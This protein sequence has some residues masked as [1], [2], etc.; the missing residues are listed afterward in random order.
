VA[1]LDQTQELNR[2]FLIFLSEYPE[3][4]EHRFGLP[5][6]AASKLRGATADFVARV[7]DYPQAIFR[8]RLQ[9]PNGRII[10]EP[11]SPVLEPAHRALQ[12]TLLLSAHS[13][14][15]AS[16]YA[17]RLFLQLSDSDINFLR[18]TR[19]S[20]LPALSLKPDLIRCAYGELRWT[21]R[22][23]LNAELT[24]RSRRL[25]LLSLMPRSK[26][27]ETAHPPFKVDH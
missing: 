25:L 19:L 4:A 27:P 8:L 11:A 15:L 22:E 12:L 10:C 21:W 5:P 3:I 7:A 20:D 13:M 1:G 2:L 17:A 23:L 18:S 6:D 26:L 14:S 24:E 9:E 16:G